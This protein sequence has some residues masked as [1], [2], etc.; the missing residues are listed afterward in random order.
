MRGSLRSAASIIV[1]LAVGAAS[2]AAQ[3]AHATITGTVTDSTGGVI[4]GASV[5]ATNVE[6]AVT[7]KTTTN[8]DG[9]YSVPQLREGLYT[10]AH[11]GRGLANSKRPISCWSPAISGRLTRKMRVGGMERSLD[12]QWQ[13]ADQ[14]RNGFASATCGRRSSCE[15][16]RS[17]IRASGPTSPSRRRSGCGAEV[18]LLRAAAAISPRSRSMARR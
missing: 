13:C 1:L 7:T 2:A 4:K 14:D 12:V 6:T 11:H 9:V 16:F 17:T 8:G 15:R 10:L 18:T 3:T 5:V